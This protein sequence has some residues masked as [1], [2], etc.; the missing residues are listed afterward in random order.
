MN[1]PSAGFPG[2]ASSSPDTTPRVNLPFEFRADGAEYF[3][4]WIV[5]LLLTIVTLGIYSAWAKVRRMRYFYGNTFLDGHSFDYHAKPIAILKGRLIIFGAYVVF[6]LLA[7][8]WPL[9]VLP[10]IPVILFGV[11]WIIMKARRFQMRVTSYRNLRFNFHGDYNGALGAFIGWYFLT[12]LTFGIIFPKWL[13]RRVE[14]TLDNTAYG[15]TRF[16][17]VTPSGQFWGFCYATAGMAA[18]AYM[19]L[20]WLFVSTLTSPEARIDSDAGPLQLLTILGVGGILG[21]LAL[22]AVG[23]GIWGYYQ[24]RF[25]NAAWGGIEIGRARVVSQQEAWPLAWIEITNVLGMICTLGLFY[26]WAKVRT[27]R[28]QLQHTSLESPGGL[29]EFEAARGEA[30]EALGEELGEFFDVDFGI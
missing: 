25:A 26:P 23:M 12:L 15:K 16:R 22:A 4:I 6:V 27:M 13:H 28:Y 14:Y 2:F 24:A 8:V 20:S 18:I 19:L 29:A 5:N 11:P 21:A 10:M 9:I 1:E 3:R 17:F 7:Q 30:G